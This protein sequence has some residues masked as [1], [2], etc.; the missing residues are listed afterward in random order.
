ME[1]S[2]VAYSL[3]H[4][5]PTAVGT[6][7]NLKVFEYRVPRYGDYICEFYLGISC[8]H[9]FEYIEAQFAYTIIRITY[10]EF[11]K[12]NMFGLGNKIPLFDDKE[13]FI[14]GLY[15][16]PLSVRLVAKE[17]PKKTKLILKWKLVKQEHLPK[18]FAFRITHKE[19]LLDFL[20]GQVV[21]LPPKE[22]KFF[23]IYANWNSKQNIKTYDLR[24]GYIYNNFI[25]TR[26]VVRA[27][28]CFNNSYIAKAKVIKIDDTTW[29]LKFLYDSGEN[30]VPFDLRN[31]P[32]CSVCVHVDY[33]SNVSNEEF[34]VSTLPDDGVIKQT[35]D[36]GYAFDEKDNMNILYTCDG[37]LRMKPK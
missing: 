13:L 1:C 27:S 29:K 6:C 21:E 17:I 19:L 20:D 23:N 32:F 5:K 9:M 10:E 14:K 31:S 37:T 18:D 33:N 36:L 30:E 24:H 15:F 25:V 11:L 2:S 28:M 26:P 34:I 8:G 7:G 4:V 16:C 3:Q 35:L 22:P 12:Y